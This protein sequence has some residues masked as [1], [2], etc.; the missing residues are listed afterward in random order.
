M[1]L[2]DLVRRVL[3]RQSEG[4]IARP[5]PTLDGPTDATPF[6]TDEVYLV[7]R[8][9]QLWLANEREL[10]REFLPFGAVVTEFLRDGNRVAVPYLIGASELS[11]RLQ[12]TGERDAVEI[13]NLRVAGPVPYEGDD[14]SLLL[15]LFRAKTSDTL[16][17]SLNLIENVSSAIGFAGLLGSARVATALIDG[18][19]SFMDSAALELR[20]G[21]HQS[22]SAPT[23]AG[24]VARGPTEL[25]PTHFV[26]IRRPA[27]KTTQAELASL[28]VVGGR[29]CR[30][31][32]D[33]TIA[34][35]TEHDFILVRVEATRHRD[36]YRQLAFFQL[37][38]RTRQHL[39][40]GD[41]GAAQVLWRQ[42]AGALCTDELIRPQQE[43]LFE[44]YQR[45][46]VALVERACAPAG[47]VRGGEH[48][49]D[50][51]PERNGATEFEDDP[52][53]L[54]RR[55]GR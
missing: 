1:A 14:V 16:Q 40:D 20:V 25:A 30:V 29:L 15:A 34:P 3:A 23:G 26:I 8:V 44:E 37:W 27:G 10:W 28:G 5:V 46:Y 32:A 55:L 39:A 42:T 35:Y 45:Q 38:Q 21:V 4:I 48:G 2:R 12:V 36:D 53:I 19:E 17:R 49:D 43:A 11:R 51:G 18:I 13:S 33:G 52:E 7:I 24:G 6:V 22:W 47:T 41:L 9:S 31:A 54:L 50:G